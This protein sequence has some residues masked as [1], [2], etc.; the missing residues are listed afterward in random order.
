MYLNQYQ[1]YA[2]QPSD[3]R[4]GADEPGS[5]SPSE[6][7]FVLSVFGLPNQYGELNWPLALRILRPDYQIRELR[8]QIEALIQVVAIQKSTSAPDLRYIL[9][10]RGLLARLRSLMDRE[11][12]SLTWGTYQEGKRFLNTLDT[13]LKNAAQR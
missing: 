7:G 3:T 4:D 10:A 13:F 8:G 6:I 11:R 5:Y 2:K 12:Y 9:L 1:A